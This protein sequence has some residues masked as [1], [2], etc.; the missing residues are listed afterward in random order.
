MDSPT[1]GDCT[2]TAAQI[3]VFRPTPPAGPRPRRSG[4][5]RF[6]PAWQPGETGSGGRPIRFYTLEPEIPGMEASMKVILFGAS[7]MVGQGVLRECLREP[8]VTEIVAI[9]R[10][11]LGRSEPKLREVVH[12]DFTDF[13]AIEPAMADA[14]ACFFCLG[15]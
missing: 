7:G 3:F 10:T 6:P 12:K 8:D 15:V 14:D 13:S 11:P 4:H 5:I 2:V 1:S 9:V